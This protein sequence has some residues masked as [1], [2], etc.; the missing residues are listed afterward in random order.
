MIT[1]SKQ[2]DQQVCTPIRTK[3]RKLY[4]H[5]REFVAN[6]GSYKI[7]IAGRRT[8]KTT[9][10]LIEALDAVSRGQTVLLITPVS[11]G[12]MSILNAINNVVLDQDISKLEGKLIIA[13]NSNYI[14]TVAHRVIVDDAEHVATKEE[15]SGLLVYPKVSFL[16]TPRTLA[17]DIPAELLYNSRFS[18]MR[19]T[20]A[21]FRKANYVVPDDSYGTYGDSLRDHELVYNA[22]Y[23]YSNVTKK[24]QK[25]F[26]KVY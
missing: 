5:Q 19:V 13:N 16:W 23:F 21:G 6:K 7:M 22:N 1:I 20:A 12:A 11:N 2:E 17:D 25:P 15:L 18:V 9:T 10:A 4:K 14:G 8:G 24:P 26:Y 3:L